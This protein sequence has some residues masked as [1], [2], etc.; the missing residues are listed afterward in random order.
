MSV[1]I[2]LSL[3][4]AAAAQVVNGMSMVPAY[5]SASATASY[6]PTSSDTSNYGYSAAASS[7]SGGYYGSA[8][9]AQYTGVTSSAA[10]APPSQYTAPPSSSVDIYSMMPYSSFMAG[11]YQSL[12]CGYGYSKASDG[13]CQA[14]S[15][16]SKFSA[17]D[18]M[19]YI[20]MVLLSVAN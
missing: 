16:V 17:L 15:W 1:F 12:D 6:P 20:L 18:H 8:A 7:S 4:S 9:P 3:A 11:G 19:Y 2:G 5:P 13:S 14:M 10:Y